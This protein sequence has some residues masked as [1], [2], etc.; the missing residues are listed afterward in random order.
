LRNANREERQPAGEEL[1]PLPA[2]GGGIVRTM[3]GRA[4]AERYACR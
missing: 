2:V 1:L 3:N 4:C